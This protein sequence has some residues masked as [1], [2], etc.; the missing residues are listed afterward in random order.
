MAQVILKESQWIKGDDKGL[1]NKVF[2]IASQVKYSEGMYGQQ[3]AID[4]KDEEGN[5][6]F[7]NLT[8]KN[9][10][11]LVSLFSDEDT[12]WLDKKIV[13]YVVPEM[14]GGVL[15]KKIVIDKA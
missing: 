15:K 7:L 13:L 3:S 8:E 2:T 12:N 10:R 11:I 9:K 1:N 6:K 4:L 5:L 14:K